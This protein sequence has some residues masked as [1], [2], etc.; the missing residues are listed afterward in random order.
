MYRWYYIVSIGAVISSIPL[1]NVQIYA[2][3]ELLV[4]NSLLRKY[5]PEPQTFRVDM[6]VES[7]YEEQ[8]YNELHNTVLQSEVTMISRYEGRKNIQDA[9]TIMFALGGGLSLI[10]GFIGIF[11]F[12]NVMSVGVM[13]RKRELATLESV[14]MSKRQ[15]RSMLRSEGV[16][17]AIITILCGATVGNAIVYGMFCLFRS[18]ANYA[19]FVYPIIPIVIL[20]AA[21]LLICLVTPEIVYR[22]VSKMTLVERL[23]ETE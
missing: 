10:L 5:F 13:A 20:C 6:N 15:V 11:N 12:V 22:G 7:D 17:Y 2:G 14:G 4:S 18:V 21:I 19:Q 1:G 9:K 8:I 23:R 16:G 3:M